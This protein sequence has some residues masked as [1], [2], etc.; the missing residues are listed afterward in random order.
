MMSSWT[1]FSSCMLMHNDLYSPNI[2]QIM[3]G[4]FGIVSTIMCEK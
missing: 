3:D 2:V 1:L 4:E